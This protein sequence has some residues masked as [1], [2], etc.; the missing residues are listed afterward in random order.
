MPVDSS[1]EAEM[2]DR[3]RELEEMMTS[4]WEDLCLALE[5]KV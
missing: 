1:V 4:V 3:I 2:K 5:E